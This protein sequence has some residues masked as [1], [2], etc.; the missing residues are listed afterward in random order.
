MEE[1]R[2][3]KEALPQLLDDFTKLQEMGD[4][5]KNYRNQ[6]LHTIFR[7][8]L[9][10]H[11]ELYPQ[12][13]SRI[14]DPTIANL[15]INTDYLD[16][17]EKEQLLTNII[18]S[19]NLWLYLIY[20][21]SYVV[22]NLFSQFLAARF[23]SDK[24]LNYLAPLPVDL[25]Q[26]PLFLHP[27]YPETI[28]GPAF[29]QLVKIIYFPLLLVSFP[30]SGGEKKVIPNPDYLPF[31]SPTLREMYPY[32]NIAEAFSPPSFKNEGGQG[33][34]QEVEDILPYLSQLAES[35]TN[36]KLK[37]QQDYQLAKS[38]MPQDPGF[39][40]REEVK[41][42]IQEKL[43]ETIPLIEKYYDLTNLRGANEEEKKLA[44]ITIVDELT[45]EELKDILSLA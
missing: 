8:Y 17:N 23:K 37:Q 18:K 28:T 44:L 21:A 20:T 31:I 36:Q 9:R 27:Y 41:R 12:F 1:K 5:D 29:V 38:K 25:T 26:L 13:L 15:L 10:D 43:E 32:F 40:L 7:V 24:I 4:K 3:W 11:P 42:R 30:P 35:Y 6:Q 14:R 22:N 33:G 34:W 16:F 45:L 39:A 19:D 2:G